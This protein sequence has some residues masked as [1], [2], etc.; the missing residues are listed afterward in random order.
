MML[1]FTYG[2]KLQQSR[3]V[4]YQGFMRITNVTYETRV[5]ERSS[6]RSKI[7]YLVYDAVY[8]VDW[9]YN[10]ACPGMGDGNNH[11]CISTVIGC[12]QDICQYGIFQSTSDDTKNPCS[13]QDT[14]IAL[15][16]AEECVLTTT[17]YDGNATYTPYD[18]PH[19][20]PS[21]DIDWP[22]LVAF[23]DCDTCESFATIP[24]PA[25]VQGNRIAGYVMLGLTTICF[26]IFIYYWKFYK[27]VQEETTTT[28]TG[29]EGAT[30]T[31]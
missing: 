20:D 26:G 13:D 15:A 23:G 17:G 27:E 18:D 25:D 24:S 22:S 2:E 1:F 9:G 19:V 12:T 5:E 29:N 6:G 4:D 21:N 3:V 30:K 8:T 11:Q 7:K 14:T 10:W 28:T 16:L 31:T